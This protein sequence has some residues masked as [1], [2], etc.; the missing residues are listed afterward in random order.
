MII[1]N[2]YMYVLMFNVLFFAATCNSFSVQ[3]IYLLLYM[4]FQ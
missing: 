4:R 3:A 2:T 1:V